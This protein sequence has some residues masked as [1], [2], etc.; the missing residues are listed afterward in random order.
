MDASRR[1]RCLDRCPSCPLRRSIFRPQTDLM[2]KW[3]TEQW[4]VRRPGPLLPTLC[5]FK[6]PRG[7]ERLQDR[8]LLFQTVH[9]Y[10]M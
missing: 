4:S 10:E 3:K 1:V 8:D 9:L 7:Q 5:S 2:L 6:H